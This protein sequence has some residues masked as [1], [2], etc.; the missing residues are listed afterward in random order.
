[1]R[2]LS[3][4]RLLTT[5]LEVPIGNV[6]ELRQRLMREA[7][8]EHVPVTLTARRYEC[9]CGVM[10]AASSDD[11]VWILQQHRAHLEETDA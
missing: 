11:A 4:S 9:V 2:D 8:L 10:A 5:L 6:T 3:A 1:M 7:G